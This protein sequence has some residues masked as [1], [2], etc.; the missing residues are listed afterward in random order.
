[1]V[2]DVDKVAR[3][4]VE[5]GVELDGEVV[6]EPWGQRHFFVRDP[7]GTHLDVIQ[8]TTPDPEWLANLP[9]S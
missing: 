3:A 2:D 5:G 8:L 1:M 7:E 4:L 6:D 9:P